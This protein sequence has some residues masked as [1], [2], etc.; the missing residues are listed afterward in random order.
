MK[1]LISDVYLKGRDNCDWKDG[2]ELYYAFKSLGYDCDIA[3][4][5]CDIPETEIPNIAHKYD[6]IILSENYPQISGWSWY[7]WKSIKTPKLFWAIDTH[8]IDYGPF[9]NYHEFDYVAFNNKVDMEKMVTNAKKI[10]LP[11]GISKKHYDINNNI[12]KEN[13]IVFIGSITQDRKKYIDKHN[14]KTFQLYGP[15]YV[16]E[17]QKAKICFNKSVSHDLNAKNMEI[18]GSGTFMLSNIN[19][20]FLNF[21]NNNE[22]ISKMFYT[23]DED[24]EY[25]INYYLNNEEEREEI[26]RNARQYIFDNHSYEKRMTYLIDTIKSM[27]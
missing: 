26:A 16:N 18:I 13:D 19:T 21:M 6:L 15:K 25:K 17:M 11:Y 22:Y 2:F 4:K 1:I 23:S 5:D 14:I 24:L 9:I 27:K 20:D 12:T 10:W 8:S 3:G 7:N